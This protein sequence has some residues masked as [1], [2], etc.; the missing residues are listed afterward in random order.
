MC[1]DGPRL[2]RAHH[3]FRRVRPRCDGTVHSPAHRRCDI[4][5]PRV[6]PRTEG[7]RCVSGPRPTGHEPF[8]RL[9][10]GPPHLSHDEPSEF[11]DTGLRASGHSF[12]GDRA[13]ERVIAVEGVRPWRRRSLPGRS[14]AFPAGRNRRP[15]RSP[16]TTEVVLRTLRRRSR[17]AGVDVLRPHRTRPRLGR[18]GRADGADPGDRRRRRHPHTE[19]LAR[20][21]R[22]VEFME[23][24]T[25]MQLLD[26]AQGVV[27]GRIA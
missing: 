18:L 21:A 23:G 13:L 17:R 24:T 25:H 4:G 27:T 1:L 26:V 7:A 2:T 8:R 20:D 6:G 15:P 22:G 10:G 12:H 5:R 16:S 3:G 11:Q 9:E 19:K 14:R